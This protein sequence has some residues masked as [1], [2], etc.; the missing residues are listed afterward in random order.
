MGMKPLLSD[1]TVLE[2]GHIVSAPSAGLIFA[3]L[4]AE[5]I[6]IERPNGGDQVRARPEKSLLLT[7]NATKRSMALNL[8]NPKGKEIFLQ[9]LKTADIVV[10]NYAPGVLERL[11]LGYEVMSQANPKII[12]C[13]IKGFLPGPYGDR[14]LLDEPAQMMGGLA[15]MTGPPGQPLR[16]GT[17]IIDIGGAMFGIIGVLAALYEREKTGRG[18]KVQ[19]GLFET[20]VFLVAKHM[21]KAGITGICPL[22]MPER[23]MGIEA[24]WIVY[25]IFMT[26]DQRMVFIAI[27]SDAHWERFCKEF[28]VRDL[29]EDLSLRTGAGRDKERTLINERVEKIVAGLPRDTLIERL[30]KSQV[31]Y[32]AV[33][34]P[35]DL[36]QDPHL[37]GRGH[38][39]RVTA[40]NGD[41]TELPAP[42]MI[43]DS[44]S[45]PI[46]T[47]PPRL[48]EHT[49]KIMADLGFSKDQIETLIQEGV[50]RPV[51]PDL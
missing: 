31:P 26:Q 29:W 41:S 46:R 2:L 38:L 12:H 33:N 27:T 45:G 32:S 17:S 18:Q 36:F 44:W 50:I 34:S 20:T 8:K 37:R 9:L 6:K 11:G 14:P 28:Q 23:G 24:G 42:P 30:E 7:Y 49:L 43:F 19:V 1:I 47:D 35:M 3:E 21:A 5:V 40:P 51:V 13:S 48:G 16:A 10:D 22:T 25:K 15:Y 39:F 4:G